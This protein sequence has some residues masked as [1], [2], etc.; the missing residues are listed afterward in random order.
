LAC[1]LAAAPLRSQDSAPPEPKFKS[2]APASGLF[3]C[4]IPSSWSP[5]EEEDALGPV[6]HILGPDNPAGTFRTGLSVRWFEPGL[7]GFLDAKKAIDFLRRP[8]RALDRHATPVRPLRVSGLLGRSFELFET[9]LLPLE[10]LPASPEVIHHYVAVIPSG[11]GY[12]VIR[13]SSTR[14]VYLDFRDEFSRF[15]KNFQ[16]LGR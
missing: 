13:L 8:D 11:A 1:L 3:A 2:Y 16:P 6:A 15:L 7:P 12:Y 5:V 14:D 9:R 4:E 10:Q